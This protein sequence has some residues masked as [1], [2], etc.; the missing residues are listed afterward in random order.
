[1]NQWIELERLVAEA[2]SSHGALHPVTILVPNNGSSLDVT[3]YLARQL[4][5]VTPL[6]NVHALT[7]TSLAVELFQT[8]GRSAGRMAA[9]ASLRQAAARA[10]LIA[11]PGVF[12]KV[13]ES[14]ATAA[15]IA[16]TSE[17]LDY[18][19]SNELHAHRLDELTA[20]VVTVHEQIRASLRSHCYFG[21][22]ALAGA[23][24]QI[25]NPDAARKLGTVIIFCCAHAHNNRER[26]FR[27]NLELSTNADV[28]EGPGIRRSDVGQ[29][30]ASARL[31]RTTDA[32]EECRAVARLIAEDIAGG[33]PGHR[34]GVFIASPIP[35]RSNLS[36]H[37]TEAGVTHSITAPIQ[38]V[39]TS[40]ARH[41]VRLLQGCLANTLHPQLVADAMADRA[42]FPPIKPFP[43]SSRV[44]LLIRQPKD[45]DEPDGSPETQHLDTHE[46]RAIR[47]KKLFAE[48]LVSLHERLRA[49]VALTSWRDVATTLR[50]V[51]D[52]DFTPGSGRVAFDDPDVDNDFVAHR[53]TLLSAIDALAALELAPL[54]PTPEGIIAQLEM[55]IASAYSKLGKS[56]VGVTVASFNSAQGRD[57]DKTY[58]LGLA[59]GIAPPRTF[60]DPLLR[61]AVIG[62][63]SSGLPTRLERAKTL[64]ENFRH[65]VLAGR[66]NCVMTYP[67]GNLR[68]GE[69]RVLSRWVA[70]HLSVEQIESA[71]I[72]G[73]FY[74]SQVSAAPTVSGMPATRP[75]SELGR[76]ARMRRD[77]RIG[78][79][80]EMNGN[81]SGH[82]ETLVRLVKDRMSPLSATHIEQYRDAPLSF[83]L[84]RVLFAHPLNDI[85]LSP[86]IDPLTRGTLIHEALEIWVKAGIA[87]EHAWDESSLLFICAETCDKYRREVGQNWV[88]QY[89]L[90]A[91]MSIEVDVRIWYRHNQSVR[92][93]GWN[94]TDAER[95]FGKRGVLDDM[96]DAV[97][98]T[99]DNELET[100]DFLG[101][102][103]RLDQGAGGSI[104]VI[105]YKT[106]Q[107]KPYEN[108]SDGNPTADG[109][110][111][112]LGVYGKLAF[113]RA[114]LAAG[115]DG[116]D[117]TV[118]EA[119][120]WFLPRN[121]PA[122]TLKAD[123][124][125][126]AEHVFLKQLTITDDVIALIGTDLTELTNDIINGA[127]PP[128][129][130][131]G[132]YDRYTNAMGKPA[133]ALVWEKLGGSTSLLDITS[134]WQGITVDAES[135]GVAY[136][137]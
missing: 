74:D 11:A 116:D 119:A 20:Q 120:Y 6:V 83:F 103:D 134:F 52:S 107:A 78:S 47:D 29:Q 110:K 19:D 68:G 48:Y 89:W 54:T 42:L 17:S 129:P 46:R 130:S 106:G 45:S 30:I 108:I 59:E 10:T 80:T 14:Y 24:E 51:I 27:A 82:R 18:V 69:E 72:V 94:P 9:T 111:Y 117:Q 122:K 8:S 133:M 90:L 55:S 95:E 12:G 100:I 118:V 88:E 104:R 16:R 56:G 123:F 102:I 41:L 60:E 92:A 71:E 32:D 58:I 97:T 93:R 98:F 61:D 35:Y 79:F 34:I 25:Q 128:K 126:M 67:H 2:K 13:S 33:M 23:T 1:M 105:D 84:Q 38:L 7:F 15:A 76:A 36:D 132:G 124:D 4:G 135:E 21:D 65:A 50:S 63:T 125:S 40:P 91:K 73:S 44:E 62:A 101:Q 43:T 81:L 37:L 85:V 22:D 66:G 57:F 121:Q 39:D 64:E 70:S 86:E 75:V 3:R 131:G 87:G 127:F 31:I 26:E 77:R 49:L 115:D 99:V 109:Y 53:E 112:Q 5:S 113:D 136:G 137:D 96:W 28:I 114:A